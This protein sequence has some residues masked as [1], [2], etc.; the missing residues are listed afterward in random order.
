MKGALIDRGC[1]VG[2]TFEHRAVQ[3]YHRNEADRLRQLRAR[4]ALQARYAA[5]LAAR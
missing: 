5:K 3:R 2:S 1:A 4:R